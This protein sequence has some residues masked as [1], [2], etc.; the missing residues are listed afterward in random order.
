MDNLDAIPGSTQNS[1]DAEST[2]NSE[3]AT[4][5]ARIIDS[6]LTEGIKSGALLARENKKYFGSH[7]EVRNSSVYFSLFNPHYIPP[8]AEFNPDMTPQEL[9]LRDLLYK[10]SMHSVLP[11]MG[12]RPWDFGNQFY[13]IIADVNNVVSPEQREEL[14][15]KFTRRVNSS[16]LVVLDPEKYIQMR[17][18]GQKVE[19]ILP[20]NFLSIL[21]PQDIAEEYAGQQAADPSSLIR[22]VDYVD[23]VLGWPTGLKEGFTAKVPNYEGEIITLA[24]SANKGIGVSGIRLPLDRIDIDHLQNWKSPTKEI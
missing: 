9:N 5:R 7:D 12:E 1:Q 15:E 13:R 18:E 20:E 21:L 6:V 24:T 8:H 23:R 4:A 3:V 2:P 16:F 17:R 19:H 11:V 10:D 14:I 22:T